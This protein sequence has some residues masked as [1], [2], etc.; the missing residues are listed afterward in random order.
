MERSVKVVLVDDNIIFLQALEIL[1][2]QSPQFEIVAK[3][4]SGVDLL[5]YKNLQGI[6]LILM[7]IEMP[8]LNGFETAIRL[9][10]LYR[11]IKK[12]AISMY[13]DRAYLD[14]LVCSG[15]RGYVSKTRVT[16]DLM[17]TI[18]RVL[19]GDLVFPSDVKTHYD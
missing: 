9:D 7:D 8:G 13:D 16:E 4:Q 3:F 12:I 17:G 14:K 6:D 1:I 10:Y 2:V 19:Q 18:E 15:F 5:N 11:D